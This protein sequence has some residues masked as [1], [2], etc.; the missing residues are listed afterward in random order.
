MSVIPGA[1]C[2][3]IGDWCYPDPPHEDPDGVVCANDGTAY[4][5]Y[6]N[7]S[8]G[9]NACVIGCGGGVYEDCHVMGDWCDPNPPHEDP[10][11]A[12]C[13]NDWTAYEAYCNYSIGPNACVVGCQ[14]EAVTG[15]PPSIAPSLLGRTVGEVA[16]TRANEEVA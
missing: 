8:I 12:V 10:D 16:G 6:C 4:E 7:Y 9:P 11:G 14:P 15:G 2:E 3:V 5:A 13:A 1:D